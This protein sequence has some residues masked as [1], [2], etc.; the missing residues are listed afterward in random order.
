[1][2]SL[3]ALLV[4]MFL[5]YN[6]MSISVVQRRRELGILRALGT[7]RRQGRL[8]LGTLAARSRFGCKRSENL[9]ADGFLLYA[10]GPLGRRTTL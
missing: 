10:P 6:T 4:G 8:N 3:V 2:G 1:M 9:R 7:T 5:I